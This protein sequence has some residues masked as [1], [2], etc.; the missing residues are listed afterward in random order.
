VSGGSV[1]ALPF[2]NA[3]TA[4]SPPYGELQS[5]VCA[6]ETSGSAD[7]WW[8]LV[9]AD[10]IRA[11][12]SYPPP[13]WFPRTRDRGWALE[14]A[15]RRAIVPSDGPEPTLGDWR[16]DVA[17]G[18]RPAV[19]FNA[20]VVETGERAVLATSAMTN[21]SSGTGPLEAQPITNQHD[22]SVFT[23][24]RLSATFPYVTPVARLDEAYL[25]P[26]DQTVP[27]KELTALLRHF[28]DGGYWD[29]TGMVTALEWLRASG[30]LGKRRV[31]V[32]QIAPAALSEPVIH[33][34]AWVWQ[35]TAPLSALLA[36]RTDAQQAR[37]AIEL[38]A[39]ADALP[40][41]IS[42]VTIKDSGQGASLG[43]HLSRAEKSA[44]ARG[45]TTIN[46]PDERKKDGSPI[47]TI[48]NFLNVS[49]GAPTP[50]P[51]RCLP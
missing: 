36:V 51:H 50:P 38:K 34:R 10:A 18:F 17:S 44:V 3:Y 8:G 24:A 39:I 9:Y 28:A 48:A 23:A 5:L 16:R 21:P 41:G 46:S 1:G 43:W 40:G 42:F 26:E 15:W 32:I 49:L 33:D 4:S 30:V 29:N 11:I 45:W 13:W 6:A 22:L 2:L 14:Q 25:P 7:I 37:N 27:S 31:L 47:T 20:T 35:W 12:V 19:A